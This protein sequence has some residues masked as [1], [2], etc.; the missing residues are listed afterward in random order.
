MLSVAVLPPPIT[1]YVYDDDGKSTPLMITA[2]VGDNR[3]TKALLDGGSLVELIS[4]KKLNKIIPPP[5][6]HNDGYIRVSL[7]NDTL[8]TL[9]RYA[10]LPINVQGVEALIKV[11]VVNVEVYDILLG[12]G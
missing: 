6:V 2:W 3:F 5:V 9:T 1:V 11:W 12:L 8:D 7:A 10:K 4:R